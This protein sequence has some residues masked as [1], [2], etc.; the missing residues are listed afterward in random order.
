MGAVNVR[1]RH[2]HHELVVPGFGDVEDIVP[3][4]G[5]DAVI[6]AWISSFDS[7]LSMRAFSTFRIFP[8]SG[9]MAW[10]VGRGPAWRC[11]R[12]IALDQ[13]QLAER[14]IA[15]LAVGQLARQAPDRARPC[16]APARGP[17]APPRA[18]GALTDLATIS[19]RS[20]GSPRGTRRASG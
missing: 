7:T 14:G 11:R 12:R 6:M 2:R 19:W 10:K 13:E 18:L 8:R 3:D 16:A 20:S 15:L 4:A 17:C 5:P 1:I 9:R